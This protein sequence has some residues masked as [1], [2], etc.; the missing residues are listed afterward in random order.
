[1]FL[2]IS[3]QSSPICKFSMLPRQIGAIAKKYPLQCSSKQGCHGLQN[4]NGFLRVRGLTETKVER[5][6]SLL[7]LRS[8]SEQGRDSYE[9]HR[10]CCLGNLPGISDALRDYVVVFRAVGRS[11]RRLGGSIRVCKSERLKVFLRPTDAN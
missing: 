2:P 6:A 7:V 1:M 8:F 3:L 4:E 11:M 10:V 5:A 9:M